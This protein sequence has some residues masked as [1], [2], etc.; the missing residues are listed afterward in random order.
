MAGIATIFILSGS[1]SASREV[2]EE[3]DI[4][5]T[6]L[7]VVCISTK[8]EKQTDSKI[9]FHIEVQL[10][11]RSTRNAKAEAA[12][13]SPLSKTPSP[14]AL[15]TNTAATMKETAAAMEPRIG[16]TMFGITIPLRNL[17]NRWT[18]DFIIN[19]FIAANKPLSNINDIFGGANDYLIK[20]W[21]LKKHSHL[22][23]GSL[24]VLP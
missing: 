6:G 13:K 22:R 14:A 4:V 2:Q 1:K 24:F 18:C 3:S 9:I 23:Q 7:T 10:W 12:P 8:E 21:I 17:P 5:S 20:I 11:H 19:A 16:A 15:F